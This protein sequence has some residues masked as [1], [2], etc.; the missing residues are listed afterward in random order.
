MRTLTDHVLLVVM[1]LQLDIH[2]D[3]EV[4]ESLTEAGPDT[5]VSEAPP[6]W[7]DD[8]PAGK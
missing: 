2:L 3:G 5:P 6:T 7:V 1:S 4:V 8:E